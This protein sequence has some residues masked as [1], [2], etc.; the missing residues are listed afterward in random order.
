MESMVQVAEFRFQRMAK[1]LPCA[2]TQPCPILV[3]YR[4][5]PGQSLAHQLGNSHL[6]NLHR[7]CHACHFAELLDVERPVSQLLGVTIKFLRFVQFNI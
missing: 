7:L 2:N 3:G 6:D 4:S 1:V 5:P